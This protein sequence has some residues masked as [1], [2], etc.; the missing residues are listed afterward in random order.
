MKLK[1]K[2]KNKSYKSYKSFAKKL[3]GPL[4]GWAGINKIN[5]I[6]RNG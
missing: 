1:N 2:I 3:A 4:I 6:M 5:K